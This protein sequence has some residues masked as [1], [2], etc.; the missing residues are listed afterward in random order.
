MSR[1]SKLTNCPNCELAVL[2][3]NIHT[4][5]ACDE[6]VCRYCQQQHLDD[7]HKETDTNAKNTD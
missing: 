3:E 5:I 7:K 1:V 6:S 4:C 2:T